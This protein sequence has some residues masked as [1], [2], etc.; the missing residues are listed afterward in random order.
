M[1]KL[2]EDTSPTAELHP[3]GQTRVLPAAELAGVSRQTLRRWYRAGKFPKPLKINGML[4]FKNSDLIEWFENN[5]SK[6]EQ[7][8]GA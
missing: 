8:Q 5:A 1:L 4:L 6:G 2:S 7:T 3:L